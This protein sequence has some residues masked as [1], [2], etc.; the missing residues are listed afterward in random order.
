MENARDNLLTR[1]AQLQKIEAAPLPL[2]T[3][4]LVPQMRSRWEHLKRGKERVMVVMNFWG[5]D[6]MDEFVVPN[7]AS[8]MIRLAAWMGV[9]RV[10]ISIYG[11]LKAKGE[12]S[13]RLVGMLNAVDTRFKDLNIPIVINATARPPLSRHA[14]AN[15]AIYL[16]SA[17]TPLTS[18]PTPYTHVLLLNPTF[19]CLSDIL[20]L[21]HQHITQDASHTCGMDFQWKPDVVVYGFKGAMVPKDVDTFRDMSG[22]RM[23]RKEDM[24]HKQ[25]FDGD[26]VAAE[27]FEDAL[28]VQIHS[29]H[30]SSSLFTLPLPHLAADPSCPA[31]LNLPT[32]D[33]T[34]LIPSSKFTYPMAP[35][36]LSTLR[37]PPKTEPLTPAISHTLAQRDAFPPAVWRSRWA[38]GERVDDQADEGG[39]GAQGTPGFVQGVWK[40]ADVRDRVEFRRY[41]GRKVEC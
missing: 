21:L 31:F 5:D 16:T 33:R 4:L 1:L 24:W 26:D 36:T 7:F 13:G 10:G 23:F 38:G 17:L 30:S 3:C 19:F 22:G 41:E 40:N 11:G 32:R 2:P 14:S 37:A 29:C 9:N 27:R 15:P 20:E 18:S 6:E 12:A 28:P 39:S 25:M 35:S 34:L 8:Q